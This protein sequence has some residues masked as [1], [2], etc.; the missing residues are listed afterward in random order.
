MEKLE[1]GSSDVITDKNCNLML[2]RW[3]DNKVVTVASTFVGKM[4][5][6]KAHHYVKAQNSR[7]ETDQPQSIFLYNKGIGGVDRLD[8][9]I[10]SYM[11]SHLS[12]KWWWPVFRFCLDLPVKNAYQLYRQQKHSEGEGK[13]DLL[14][15]RGSIIDTYYRC[16][17]K[18]TTT[19]IFS[20]ARKL[21][22][23]SDEVRYDSINHWIG[24]GKQR[25]C[26]SC[27]KTTLYFCEK[28]NVGRHPDCHKQ[29]NSKK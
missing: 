16:L 13:L 19:N 12:K 6:W 1:R 25:R 9:N 17:R 26:V 21:S 23:V 11:T 4:P 18:S 29:F 7:A 10:R 14:G 24:K 5:L 2:V 28:C 20:L 27:Q 3:K 8:Q 22:K 15:L